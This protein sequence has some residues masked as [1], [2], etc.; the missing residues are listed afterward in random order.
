MSLSQ[1]NR[2]LQ[3]GALEWR[4]LSQVSGGASSPNSVAWCASRDL[5]ALM[6][7]T[8]VQILDV[9]EYLSTE[10]AP[11]AKC[12]I[13]IENY[14]PRGK[15]KVIT[16]AQAVRLR[17]DAKLSQA[18][19][20]QHALLSQQTKSHFTSIAW[21][22]HTSTS[23]SLNKPG[24][25]Q[26]GP[27]SSPAGAADA[28]KRRRAA[29][30]TS[31]GAK[32]SP[33][34]TC[35]TGEEDEMDQ[36]ESGVLVPKSDGAF[37]DARLAV[38]TSCG[39]VLI[40]GIS[41]VW[42]GPYDVHLLHR[43]EPQLVPQLK[44][45][46]HMVCPDHT[47]CAFAADRQCFFTSFHNHVL[48]WDLSTTTDTSTTS[49]AA[50]Q[51]HI[52]SKNTKL[53]TAGSKASGAAKSTGSGAKSSSGAAKSSKAVEQAPSADEA[54]Q[55][56]ACSCPRLVSN[57]KLVDAEVTRLACCG[58]A[59]VIGLSSGRVVHS[60]TD[61]RHSHVLYHP[62]NTTSPAFS[63]K[64]GHDRR[65]CPVHMLDFR[66]PNLVG[67]AI[68]DSFLVLRQQGGEEK[69]WHV[70][71]EYLQSGTIVGMHVEPDFALSVDADAIACFF[72]LRGNR[73][74]MSSS[75]TPQDV[76]KAGHPSTSAVSSSVA[77]T[78]SPARRKMSFG[79][80]EKMKRP[81]AAADEENGNEGKQDVHNFTVVDNRRASA[82]DNI[83]VTVGPPAYFRT[84]P[85][86]A[87][88][89]PQP[90]Q[91]PVYRPVVELVLPCCGAA[92]S[93][94]RRVL[95][96]VATATPEHSSSYRRLQSSFGTHT[97]L[98]LCG[99]PHDLLDR[100]KT[101]AYASEAGQ[102]SIGTVVTLE[103]G[104][105]AEEAAGEPFEKRAGAEQLATIS[106]LCEVFCDFLRSGGERSVRVNELSYNALRH[107]ISCSTRLSAFEWKILET[108]HDASS[109]AVASEDSTAFPCFLH[110]WTD[111]RGQVE[112]AVRIFAER[113]WKACTTEPALVEGAEEFA[114]EQ[115]ELLAKRKAPGPAVDFWCWI[116]NRARR[117]QPDVTGEWFV[118]PGG[119]QTPRCQRGGDPIGPGTHVERCGTCQRMSRLARST[120]TLRPCYYCLSK[121]RHCLV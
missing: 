7:D 12:K 55:S 101:T 40:F 116:C 100:G 46:R 34:K 83:S 48:R 66:Y 33:G 35:N 19:L 61:F 79:G 52:I 11:E 94:G 95:A 99:L 28:M 78:G 80:K 2:T 30:A 36:T 75:S 54:A 87:E 41:E 73:E 74:K 91:L 86:P 50:E 3:P 93:P 60:D 42:S 51:E 13:V 104:R 6:T 39:K 44:Q 105:L 16:P 27:G 24:G 67:V 82:N 10:G 53:Q 65:E 5:L 1:L 92:F 120:A 98:W 103:R 102:E 49:T 63:A 47:C 20:L 107:E 8:V 119:H 17:R 88:P 121:T 111:F 56:A 106:D 32:A 58:N 72:S 68:Q 108:L 26:V 118:C 64:V 113:V 21:D 71:L 4:R 18:A 38:T 115:E 85:E 114:Q 110:G 117:L 112:N 29:P 43:I 69:Q 90:G 31:K 70:I 57:L 109:S 45:D 97:E 14:C 23:S 96:S 22:D 59:I 84:V 37:I 25:I 9:S 15:R 77:G 76:D 89:V 81:K 62:R